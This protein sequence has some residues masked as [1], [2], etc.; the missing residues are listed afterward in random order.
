MHKSRF[1]DHLAELRIQKGIS[2]RDMSLSLGQSNN[3]INTIENGKALPSMQS[4]FNICDFLG[5]SPQEFFDTENSDPPM[6]R[7]FIKEAQKLDPKIM[8]YFLEIMKKVNH[9][10]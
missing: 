3:Y 8:G 1:S 7:E 4:F 9:T 5:I 10:P 2:A 6:L